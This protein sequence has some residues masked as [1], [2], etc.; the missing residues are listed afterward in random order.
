MI[1]TVDVSLL[2]GPVEEGAKWLSNAPRRPDSSF[3]GFEIGIN[4]CFP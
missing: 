2:R 3:R 1:C 4:R